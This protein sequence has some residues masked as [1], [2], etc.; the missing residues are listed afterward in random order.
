MVLSSEEVILQPVPGRDVDKPCA[1]HVFN[2]GITSKH[3]ASASTERMLILK[4]AE[5]AAIEA[6]NDLITIPAAL[7]RYRW[8]QHCGDNEVLAAVMDQ[9]V[10]EGRVVS[11]SQVGRQ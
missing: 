7:F 3:S 2:E 9:R 11:H 6:A 10:A 4:L 8:Q 1:G 5:V